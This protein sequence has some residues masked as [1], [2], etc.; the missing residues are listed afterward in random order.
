MKLRLSSNYREGKAPPP[1]FFEVGN[2]PELWM[3]GMYLFGGVAMLSACWGGPSVEW[4]RSGVEPFGDRHSG[5]VATQLELGWRMLEVR[6]DLKPSGNQIQT[7]FFCRWWWLLYTFMQI[8][9]VCLNY[10]WK[11]RWIF[12]SCMKPLQPRAGCNQ[13]RCRGRSE[14]FQDDRGL[15]YSCLEKLVA[16]VHLVTCLVLNHG[17]GWLM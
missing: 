17:F 9:H 2:P 5:R 13:W 11:V 14:V 1:A 12:L 16:D 10:H 6:K 8:P 3:L 15:G 7:L 4:W